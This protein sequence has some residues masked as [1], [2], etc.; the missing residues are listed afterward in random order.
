M[1]LLDQSGLRGSLDNN[2]KDIE[3][4]SEFSE[5]KSSRD[6]KK[7][8]TE[9]YFSKN[10]YKNIIIIIFI[11]FSIFCLS[12]LS[13]KE[14]VNSYYDYKFLSL[15]NAITIED[16][17]Y[18]KSLSINNNNLFIVAET[19]K[20]KDIFRYLPIIEKIFTNIKLKVDRNQ[21]Q[22]WINQ[23]LEHTRNRSINEIFNIIDDIDELHIEKEIIGNKLVAICN[24]DDFNIIFKYFDK[25]KLL[26][27]EFNLEFIKYKSD[28]R[29]YKLTI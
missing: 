29:Y 25:I 8:R 7:S 12:V 1:N 28:N 6:I 15:T 22:I 19:N 11:I 23:R 17:L 18:I 21:S 5:K 14:N 27:F 16:S 24:M 26:N 13:N 20:Q 2:L 9:K 4:V 3:L 10:I